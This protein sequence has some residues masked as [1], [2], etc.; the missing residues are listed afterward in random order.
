MV[1][2]D[3]NTYYVRE[4]NCVGFGKWKSQGKPEKNTNLSSTSRQ[5]QKY[6]KSR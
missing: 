2:T 6:V 4:L 3:F 5:M 1:F